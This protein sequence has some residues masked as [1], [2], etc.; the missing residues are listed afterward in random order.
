MS[1]LN[2]IL[3]FVALDDDI[4]T[5]GQPRAEQFSTLAA[6]GYRVVI[7]LAM[8]TGEN[9]L[10]DEG[11]IVTTLG[12]RYV[13][14]P[15]VWERPTV[16]DL[17]TFLG[18]MQVFAGQKIHV[19]CAMNFRVSGFMYHYLRWVRGRDDE[20]ARSP[21]FARWAPYMDDTWRAFLALTPADVHA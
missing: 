13:H 6:A 18:V 10:P 3:N 15:V 12:M 19:H 11:S 9:G 7:N 16:D 21:M 4:G 1:N 8:P 2:D 20:S 5:S 14:I 17:K